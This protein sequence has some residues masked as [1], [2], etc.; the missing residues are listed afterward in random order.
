MISIRFGS[1][2]YEVDTV[3]KHPE[4][5]PKLIY[6]DIGIVKTKEEI[7]FPFNYSLA[8]LPETKDVLNEEVLLAGNAESKD[9]STIKII[10]FINCK[11]T[12]N[13]LKQGQLKYGILDDFQFCADLIYSNLGNCPLVSS[14]F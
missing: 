8:C 6:H 1:E 13:K 3:T 9:K 4:Y 5:N 7:S 12:V 2:I 11:Q 14:G 10:S